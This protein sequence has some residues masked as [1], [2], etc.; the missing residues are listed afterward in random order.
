M[1]GS[2]LT[3]ERWWAAYLFAHPEE[4]VAV[5]LREERIPRTLAREKVLKEAWRQ[6]VDTSE[7]I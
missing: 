4:P 1:N 2:G 3:W 7:V 6:D 5:T